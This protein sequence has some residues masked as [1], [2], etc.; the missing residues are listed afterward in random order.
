MRY[1]VVDAF[2]DKMFGGNPAAVCILEQW[3]S[4]DLMQNIAIENNLSETAFAVK[5]DGIYHIRWFTPGGEI[6]LC[7]HAT[8]ATAFIISNYYDQDVTKIIFS[9]M[10]G[11]L[12][13]KKSGDLFELNFPSIM[14]IKFE[15]SNKMID[16]LGIK[17]I[18]TY[19][20][21][22]LI[23]ILENED[24]VL[25]TQPN[26]TKML[27]LNDG[28]GVIITAKGVHHDFV[29]RA[30]YPKLNVKEDP[31]TGSAHS[32]LIPYWARRLNKTKLVARQLSKRGG[33]LYCRDAGDR[34]YISG[35]ATLYAQ[36]TL[37]I[38]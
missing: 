21:R 12:I 5:N 33:T 26:F 32:N 1:Y 10:S 30:F 16:A 38:K 19:L 17:P 6:D 27:Q 2:T 20:A 7:G 23:F 4:D 13:V 25:S 11:E 28:L 29:S 22:D 31:V 24:A 8:L 37:N 35:Y 36:G 18:E 15:L 3:I 34:V 9:S 14:P